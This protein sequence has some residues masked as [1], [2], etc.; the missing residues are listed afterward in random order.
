M[1]CTECDSCN[2]IFEVNGFGN[3]P[4]QLRGEYLD[5]CNDCLKAIEKVVIEA[6]AIQ[7]K[8]YSR[9]K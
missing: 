5:L 1:T 9:K 7:K 2:R 4:N 6:I 3:G 8:K